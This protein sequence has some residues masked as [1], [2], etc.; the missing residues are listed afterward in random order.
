MNANLALYATAVLISVFTAKTRRRKI[1][2]LFA[3]LIV[4]CSIAYLFMRLLQSYFPR[5]DVS[6][7]CL[8]FNYQL[9]GSFLSIVCFFNC[10]LFNCLLIYE[11]ASVILP[12]Q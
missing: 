12:S 8:L 4:Y 5:N 7:Y 10:L 6:L 3:F 11:I 2:Y 9:N 1:F